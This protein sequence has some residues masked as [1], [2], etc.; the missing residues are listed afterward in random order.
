MLDI[1]LNTRKNHT[2]N[3]IDGGQWITLPMED[4]ELKEAMEAI[5]KSLGENDPEWFIYDHEWTCEIELFEVSENKSIETIN[6]RLQGIDK[7][8]EYDQKE[9][10]AAIEAY[11]YTLEK[12][13]EL[14]KNDHFHLHEGMT[15]YEVA[16]QI[17]HKI[18]G[19]Q[20]SM[21]FCKKYFDYEAFAKD[22]A[23][24]G[25]TQTQYGVIAEDR[26]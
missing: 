18:M 26:I 13:L 7:L 16:V 11:S 4:E 12:A 2:S 22:L 15:L 20:N 10:A 17:A 25:Y 21:N 8:S 23:K 3:D 9:I 14:Q 19:D 24:E 6:N 1:Y 5:A